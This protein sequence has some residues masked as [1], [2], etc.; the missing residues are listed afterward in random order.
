MDPPLYVGDVT[1]VKG[2]SCGLEDFVTSGLVGGVLVSGDREGSMEGTIPPG[3]GVGVRGRNWGMRGD[4]R[5]PVGLM[6]VWGWMGR[7]SLGLSLIPRR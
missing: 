5:L 4:S 7:V 2:W 6:S 1:V 3:R